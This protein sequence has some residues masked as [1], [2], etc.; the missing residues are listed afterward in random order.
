MPKTARPLEV[1][2]FVWERE[3]LDGYRKPAPWTK[4]VK[5]WNEQHPGHRFKSA[6]HFCTYFFR[7]DAALRHLNF[8]PPNFELQ[9]DILTP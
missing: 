7:G 4:W 3:R 9:D 2:R 6:G 1:A 5:Q 8:D